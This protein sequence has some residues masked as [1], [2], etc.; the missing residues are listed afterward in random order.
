MSVPIFLS[1]DVPFTLSCYHCDAGSPESC[2]E[3]VD[4]GW[5]Y[6]QYTPDGLTENYLGL[7]PECANGEF[8]PDSSESEDS[9]V[10]ANAEEDSFTDNVPLDP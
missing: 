10:S 3:A 5:L 2:Q 6:I 4:A 8:A 1:D 9:P 7:C